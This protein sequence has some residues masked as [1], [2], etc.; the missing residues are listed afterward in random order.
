MKTLTIQLMD[1][2]DAFLH[3]PTD[4]TPEDLQ[5]IREHIDLW[6]RIRRGKEPAQ[7]ER[8]A[9]LL[10]NG[11]TRE[12]K[13]DGVQLYY[14]PSLGPGSPYLLTLEQAWEK[15]KETKP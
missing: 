1:R 7:D 5:A 14:H 8:E 2:R 11:W 4:Y 13:P 6:E 15:H 3:L 10:W 9:E 12:Q